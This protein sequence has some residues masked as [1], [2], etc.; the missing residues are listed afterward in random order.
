[1]DWVVDMF[2]F[3]KE[4]WFLLTFFGG[5]AYGGYKGIKTLND[6]LIDIKNELKMSNE[7]FKESV[8]DRERIWQR[9]YQHDEEIDRLDIQTNRHDVQ[10]E[11]LE[12]KNNI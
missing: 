8:R 4:W 3:I 9:L 1:M 7:R 11:V 2:Y 5:L 10:I 12:R 6:T